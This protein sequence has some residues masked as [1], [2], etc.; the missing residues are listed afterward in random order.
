ME[1]LPIITLAAT[2]KFELGQLVSTPNALNKL[3]HRDIVTGLNRHIR[4][5]WGELDA[6]DKQ[7][8]DRALVQGTRLFSG[9]RSVGGVRFWIITEWD[10]SV[11]TVLLPEDY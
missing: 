8:N 2:P 5:D 3:E 11:T 9:Y 4:G 10:R 7:A 6:E 1:P